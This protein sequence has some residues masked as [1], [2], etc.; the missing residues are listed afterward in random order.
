MTELL[1]A[2]NV[3][4][5]IGLAAAFVGIAALARQVGVLFERVAP[6]GA[7]TLHQGPQVGA[8]APVL[9]PVSINKGQVRIGGS[10]G[11]SQLIM[12]VGPECPVCRELLPAFRSFASAEASDLDVVLASDGGEPAQH[13]DYIARQGVAAIPYVLSR[14]LGIAFGV[15]KVPY[16]VLIDEDGVLRSRGL[17]N[18]RQH[19]ESLLEAKERGVASMQEF[20][21]QLKAG[22]SA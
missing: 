17:I 10:R 12:F 21:S 7:L 2:L 16:A 6:A 22:S 8:P 11:R 9:S 1:V 20:R 19:L 3:M 4:L 13:L 5:L 15:A 18:S 14:E